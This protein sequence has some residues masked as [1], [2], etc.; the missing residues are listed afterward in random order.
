MNPNQTNKLSIEQAINQAVPWSF[1]F[2]NY[3]ADQDIAVEDL[4][5]CSRKLA[6]GLCS[7]PFQSASHPRNFRWK[8][9]N[10]HLTEKDRGR[11][12][13]DLF[14]WSR[15]TEEN[16]ENLIRGRRIP[17][18]DSNR[19]LLKQISVLCTKSESFAIKTDVRSVYRGVNHLLSNKCQERVSRSESVATKT[20][21]ERVPMSEAVATQKDIST[22]NRRVN[23]L[24][25][26]QMSGACT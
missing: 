25:L 2:D 3:S 12:N 16:D 6:I 24:V 5:P 8:F 13:S 7:E 1:S 14:H 26:K 17:G 18:R 10:L 22:V 4:S 23:Y 21:Q 11:I 15:S 9:D 20:C 19:L